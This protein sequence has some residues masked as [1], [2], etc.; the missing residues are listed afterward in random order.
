MERKLT[1]TENGQT[2]T[3]DWVTGSD[4]SM[5]KKISLN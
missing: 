3:R 2:E 4:F 5:P 1:W